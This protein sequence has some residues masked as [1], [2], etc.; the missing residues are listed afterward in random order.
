MTDAERSTFRVILLAVQAGV[1]AGVTALEAADKGVSAIL[2]VLDVTS[3]APN[4]KG[5]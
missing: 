2:T 3:D 5:H 4:G 1:R